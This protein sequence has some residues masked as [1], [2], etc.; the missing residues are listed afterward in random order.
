M[1]C[2]AVFD[3]QEDDDDEEEEAEP[4]V[5]VKKTLADIASIKKQANL[6]LGTMDA[7]YLRNEQDLLGVHD[8]VGIAEEVRESFSLWPECNIAADSGK[9]TI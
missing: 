6:R 1:Q 3:W 5:P 7:G 4:A 8:D 2:S 9:P